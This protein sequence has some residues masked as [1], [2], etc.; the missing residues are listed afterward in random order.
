MTDRVA[1]EWQSHQM[2]VTPERLGMRSVGE[3]RVRAEKLGLTP[4]PALPRKQEYWRLD[5]LLSW[6]RHNGLE[7]L[8]VLSI[9]VRRR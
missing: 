8:P 2:V 1:G 3:C 6:S 7:Y 9:M 5:T 4:L